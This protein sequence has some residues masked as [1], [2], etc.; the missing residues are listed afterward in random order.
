MMLCRSIQQ[1]L[2]RNASIGEEPI[3]DVVDLAADAEV[4]GQGDGLLERDSPWLCITCQSRVFCR[5][6][7]QIKWA[8]DLMWHF[9]PVVSQL[10]G[11]LLQSGGQLPRRRNANDLMNSAH[12]RD[13]ELVN[14]LC[15]IL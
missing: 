13:K 1:Q 7:S 4:G 6:L 3:I 5:S 15:E 9:V 10:L 12:R 11:S 2:K 8:V 14:V